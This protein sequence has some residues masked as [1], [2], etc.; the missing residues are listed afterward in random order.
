M[1]DIIVIGGGAAGMTAA[2]YAKRSGKSVKIFE[3]E[4]FGGQIANSPKVEN[5]PSIKEISGLELSNNM[6]EQIMDL[7]VEFECED[8]LEVKKENDCFIV[9]TDYNTYLAKAVIIA[10]GVKHRTMGVEREEELVGKGVSYCAVCDGAFYKG[11][12]VAVIGDANTALQYT[13]MLSDICNKVYLCML[14]DKF[15][16]DQT[17][18]NRLND[19]N[20]I[21]VTK[22]ILLKEFLGKD[23]LTGL[24]FEHTKTNEPFSINC[25]A[26]FI[27]IGQV[28]NN[29]RYSN[30]VDIDERGYIVSTDTTT[31]T[32]GL[33]VAGDCR[34]KN[35][36]Q[37][38]TAVG[39]GAIAAMNAVNYI[40]NLK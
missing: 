33:Y 28:P 23:E 17:L 27:A 37:L 32:P 24:K 15:F 34:T 11:K 25:E 18:V 6:F 36:R 13:L 4:S 22:E 19:R 40:N 29:E 35:V 3:K 39:D 5:F 9:T 21:V 31:K 2:L 26:V 8:V 30:L 10:A 1:I 14:F 38:T 12:D 7:G 20:N 16:A